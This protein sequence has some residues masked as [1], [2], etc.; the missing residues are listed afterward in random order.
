MTAKQQTATMG[1]PAG[2]HASRHVRRSKAAYD[3]TCQ[4]RVFFAANCEI[5]KRGQFTKESRTT[6]HVGI[7]MFETS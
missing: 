3:F 5:G 4:H 7:D 1:W 6:P 2:S